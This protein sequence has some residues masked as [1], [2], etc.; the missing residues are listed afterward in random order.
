MR[1]LLSGTNPA[2]LCPVPSL[3][4]VSPQVADLARRIL[5]ASQLE[6]WQLGRSRVFLRAGQL[7]Q[8]EGARGRRL[9]AAAVRIQAAWRGMEARQTLRRARA[10]ALAIQSAWRG[11]T[12]RAAAQRR[13]SERAAV[14]VQAA[15]RMHRARSAFQL[16]R[17][18]VVGGGR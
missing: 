18:W 10:A 1:P 5:F 4:N 2:L 6:G 14:R 13:R 3:P 15:W 8:L 12:A 7:A 17:R 16:H 9:S 11:H